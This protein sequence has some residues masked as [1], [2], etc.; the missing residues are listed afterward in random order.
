[1]L[2]Y[3]HK[4]EFIG[5]DE[6]DLRILGL[7]SMEDLKQRCDDFSSLFINKTGY[8]YNFSHIHWIDY[9][10]CADASSN[11]RVAIGLDD[12]EFEAGIS[13]STLYLS[14][15]PSQKAYV[16]NLQNL[17]QR[18]SGTSTIPEAPATLKQ[19]TPPPPP[20]KPEVKPQP[21]EPIKKLDIDL[22][23]APKKQT[24]PKEPISIKQ[25]DGYSFDPQA[26]SK[27]LGLPVDLIEEF[28]CDFVEQSRGFKQN[29]T[30]HLKEGDLKN[31]RILAHQLKGVAA[32][33]RIQDALDNLITMNVSSDFIEI[34]HAMDSFYNII[35][36]LAHQSPIEDSKI[37]P[38]PTLEEPI[39]ESEEDL[40]LP[41]DI[42]LDEPNEPLVYDKNRVAQE[43]GLELGIFNDIFSQYTTEA[44]S[45]ANEMLE[46]AKSDEPNKIVPLAKE[47]KSMSDNMRVDIF[48]QE[49]QSL[50]SSTS[51]DLTGDVDQIVSKLNQ[52]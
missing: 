30:T 28:V 11:Y 49:L 31:L 42:K 35:E 5:I 32:N 18:I 8:V 3:N 39:V 19:A 37:C 27:E 47:L 1:M 50:I 25:S 45:I 48:N 13:V 36:K 34:K 46:L 41:L 4:K 2:I 14:D 7:S 20:P 29:L 22:E 15:E 24:P 23:V 51:K 38:K 44:K 6:H 26:T 9:L 21:I 16:V 40:D 33:L 52:L 10:M 43:I 12:K 17:N